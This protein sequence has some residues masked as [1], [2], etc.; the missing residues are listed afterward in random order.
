MRAQTAKEMSMSE[1]KLNL[2]RDLNEARDMANGL[3]DYVRGEPL[4][5]S[6]GGGMF[7]SGNKP[8]L[9]VGALVL[10]LQRLRVLREHLTEAQKTQLDAVD[11]Q[12]Q[13]VQ[14]EWTMHYEEK[15]LRE[16]NSRLDA[17]RAY[18]E[19]CA[20][21]PRLCANAYMPEALRRTIVQELIILMDERNIASETLVTKARNT[22]G[23]LRKVTQASEFV[24]AKELAEVYPKAPFWWLYQ[25]PPQPEA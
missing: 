13:T 8:A 4:Y 24:W 2:G 11:H 10:R 9:T 17:M 23:N 22:D 25:R 6:L 12:H 14:R 1:Q 21:N 15:V 5:G 3:A 20:Q 16:A 18:F 7:G 19:E